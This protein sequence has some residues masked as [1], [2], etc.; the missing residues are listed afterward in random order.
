MNLRDFRER[1]FASARRQGTPYIEYTEVEALNALIQEQLDIYCERTECVFMPS[2]AFTPVIG[3]SYFKTYEPDPDGTIQLARPMCRIENV[4]IG[5]TPLKVAGDADGKFGESSE[6]TV[7]A[8]FPAYLTAENARPLH[9]FMKTPTAVQFNCPF[10]Q[11]YS[12]CFFSGRCFHTPLTADNGGDNQILDL[13][14]GDIELAVE[15]CAIA[16]LMP[17]ER[18]IAIALRSA[19]D[20]RI[21]ARMG[22]NASMNVGHKQRGGFRESA[23]TVNLT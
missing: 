2:V 8:S 1:V 9:W 5:G 11:V 17:L 7:L 20:P 6:R 4:Y 16:L 23:E 15:C 3:D 13:P 10:D 12:D 19:L 18:E 14:P 21:D 22:R